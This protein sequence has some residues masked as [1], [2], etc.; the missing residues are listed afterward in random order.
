MPFL[1]KPGQSE[2]VSIDDYLHVLK[3]FQGSE[4]VSHDEFL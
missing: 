1:D 2:R 3:F 4:M